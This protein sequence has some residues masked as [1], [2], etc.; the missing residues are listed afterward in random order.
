MSHLMASLLKHND[1]LCSSTSVILTSVGIN[2]P[3]HL[4]IKNKHV[5]FVTSLVV[6]GSHLSSTSLCARF[7][8]TFTY[9]RMKK[10]P[11]L[12]IKNKHVCFV[13][14]SILCNFARNI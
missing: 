2:I 1:M 5:C 13:L 4:G 9:M 10:L 6:S 3:T 8:V 12:G 14:R 11:H 7:Y